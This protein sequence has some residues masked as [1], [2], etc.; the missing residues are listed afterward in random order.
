MSITHEQ[1]QSL[2]QSSLDRALNSEERDTLS[3]H[4]QACAD[5]QVF[6]DE[7]KELEH[8]IRSAFLERYG[9]ARPHLNMDS[10]IGKNQ[11]F[12]FKRLVTTGLAAAFLV[13]SATQLMQLSNASA[14]DTPA[15]FAPVPTPSPQMTRTQLVQAGCEEIRYIIQEGDTLESLSNQFSIS[16]ETLLEGNEFL[17]TSIVPGMEIS[18]SICGT[19]AYKSPSPPTLTIT[20]APVF[21]TA[22]TP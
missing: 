12:S 4:L 14:P 8:S 9:T 6:S 13:L 22:F 15:I 20:A 11:K 1:A 7:M 5:C 21:L 16:Y 2:I 18:L 10:I 17:A 19:Q 3:G